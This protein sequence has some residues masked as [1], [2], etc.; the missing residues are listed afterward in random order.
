[1]TLALSM[2]VDCQNKN[3]G[4]NRGLW[5]GFFIFRLIIG[6]TCQNFKP[7]LNVTLSH[8]LILPISRTC[9][10][11]DGSGVRLPKQTTFYPPYPLPA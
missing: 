9:E 2:P 6:N 10:K 3:R 1:M 7:A 5:N 11:R 4:Q 8:C